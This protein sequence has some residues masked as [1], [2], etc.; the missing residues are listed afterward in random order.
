MVPNIEVTV[1]LIELQSLLT[2]AQVIWVPSAEH[3]TVAL[4]SHDTPICCDI[5]NI[6]AVTFLTVL[7]TTSRISVIR[8]LLETALDGSVDRVDDLVVENANGTRFAK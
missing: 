4:H 3:V 8:T 7:E 5:R 6:T 1:P 2:T